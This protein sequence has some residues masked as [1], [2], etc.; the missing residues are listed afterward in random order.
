MAGIRAHAAAV[1]V[2]ICGA[3]VEYAQEASADAKTIAAYRLTSDGLRKVINV[4]R[5]ILQT[6]LTDPKVQESMKI[7]AEIETLSKKDE[8]SAA[9]A[10]RL[11]QLETRREQLEEAVD[12][13]IGGDVKSLAEMEGRIRKYPPMVQALKT[14]GM[15]PREYSI[16]WMAFLQA[17]LAHG[18]QK[19]GMMQQLPPD[20]SPDN[21]K[22]VAEH[23]AEIE[24]MQ[25]EFEGLGRRRQ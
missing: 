25:K 22:F 12:N 10:V 3:S 9:E 8:L 14:E 11:E 4:N 18:F 16:F 20:V 15:S 19:A 17:A 24:A 1:A 6:V 21:V 2:L 23:Q 13:P 7:S 5:A